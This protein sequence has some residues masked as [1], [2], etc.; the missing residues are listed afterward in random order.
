MTARQEERLSIV[1]LIQLRRSRGK[2]LPDQPP[3]QL[4]EQVLSAAVQAPNH[5]DT[6]PWRFFVL[7]GEARNNL[8]DALASALARRWNGDDP[9]KLQGLL[10]AERAKPMRSPVLIV[11]GVSSE[12][13]DPMTKRED[14]QAAS[15]A[16]QNMLLAACSLGLAAIWRTGD[17]AYDASVK[18][19]FGLRSQDEI[20][21]IL[22][23]GY[24]DASAA[25]PDARQRDFS[26][27]TE[28]R[29]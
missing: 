19:H 16:L 18:A 14:L 22:Y 23:L 8:G 27:K 2:M 15:A 11:V 17:G 25:D 20:A 29:G 6:Q 12:R 21:G 24:P 7:T 9:S 26:G 13:D 1:E 4:I 28:W 10:V 5:H 3:R